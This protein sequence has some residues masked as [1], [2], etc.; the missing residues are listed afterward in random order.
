MR[1]SVAMFIPNFRGRTVTDSSPL[2]AAEVKQVG[3]MIADRQ[4]GHGHSGAVQCIKP[5][6]T[7]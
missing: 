6:F 7:I 3:L 1:L 5:L 4:A 2:D